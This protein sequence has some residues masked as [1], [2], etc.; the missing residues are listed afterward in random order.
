MGA[1]WLTGDGAGLFFCGPV[2][3]PGD[4]SRRVP[5]FGR[6]GGGIGVFGQWSGAGEAA[7]RAS[8]PPGRHLSSMD[9]T[10]WNLA[11]YYG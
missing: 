1:G 5:V 7:C 9:L 10:F 3:A 6:P 2:A 4:W 11:V 8:E